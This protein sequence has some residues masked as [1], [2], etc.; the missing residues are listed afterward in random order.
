MSNQD[1][2]AVKNR[3]KKMLLYIGIFSIVMLFGAFTSAYIVA[4]ADNFWVVMDLPSGFYIS[5][6]IIIA[7]SVTMWL[8]LK[9]AKSN[10]TNAI[11]LFLLLTLALGIGFSVAQF[12]GWKEMHAKGNYVTENILALKGEYGK[13]YSFL[14]KGEELIEAD[15]EFYTKSD[16]TRQSPLKD[17]LMATRNANSSYIYLITFLHLLHLVG[18]LIYLIVTLSNAFQNKFS[19]Q[20][21]LRLELC[22]TY[23]HFL[24]ALWIYLLLFLLFI[25]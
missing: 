15:G 25:H 22:G 10:N 20:N 7:S 1:E 8:A 3:S 19:A 16:V 17:K 12:Q 13:D 11:K 18:G 6:V 2:I 4:Q 21:T 5:T 23:W 24:D 9:A 14:Y